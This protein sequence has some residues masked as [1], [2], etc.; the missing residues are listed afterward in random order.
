MTYQARVQKTSSPTHNVT[1]EFVQNY[2]VLPLVVEAPGRVNLIG[3]HTDYNDG[4]VLPAAIQL[5]TQVAVAA[6]DDGR[7]VI[8]SENY[9]EQVAFEMAELLQTARQHWSDYVVARAL[10]EH[11]TRL[12]AASLLIHASVPLGAGLSSSTSLDVAICGAFLAVNNV[13][14][15][16]AE[17]ALLCQRAE[18][19]FVGARCGIMDQFVAVHGKNDRALLLDCRSLEYRQVS[20]PED[21]W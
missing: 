7:L 18:N 20:I 4:F 14:L 10:E 21:L 3:E 8:T 17:I 13:K 9:S 5:R 6:R 12:S 2:G 15:N 11:G 19:E 16:D 1:H